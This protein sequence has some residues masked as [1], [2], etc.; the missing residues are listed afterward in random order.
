ML[1]DMKIEFGVD[2]IIKEI[3]F[4]DVIDNDFW[5]LWL[6]GDWSQQK[7]KQFYCDFKEVILEGFQMV[8]K[9]FE[10]VVD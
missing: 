4:V 1:V 7:D 10:W 9:N 8:K 5:R 6:L 3:V 2:V